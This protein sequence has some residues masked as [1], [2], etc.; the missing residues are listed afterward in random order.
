M[1]WE[2]VVEAERLAF[3]TDRMNAGGHRHKTA[4]APG[5]AWHLPIR[6]VRRVGRILRE[7]V[8]DV[9]EQQFLVLLLVMQPDL[10]N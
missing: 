5:G 9:G 6:I 7:G 1:F 3:V 10:H 4:R 2:L 8:Q